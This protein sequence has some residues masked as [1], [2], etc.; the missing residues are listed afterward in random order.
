MNRQ[1]QAENRNAFDGSLFLC[2]RGKHHEALRCIR[3]RFVSQLLPFNHVMAFILLLA[4]FGALVKSEVC[5][6]PND[7]DNFSSNRLVS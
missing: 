7:F 4:I 2:R 6:T 5:V 3:L 1:N